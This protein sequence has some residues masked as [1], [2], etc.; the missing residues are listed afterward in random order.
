MKKQKLVPVYIIK[1]MIGTTQQYVADISKDTANMIVVA[2]YTP[3]KYQA[4]Q[5]NSQE[6][7]NKAISKIKN[8]HQRVFGWEKIEVPEGRPHTFP[9]AGRVS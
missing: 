1:T 4:H 2:G 5:W 6:E 3:D 9:S 7:A 8:P